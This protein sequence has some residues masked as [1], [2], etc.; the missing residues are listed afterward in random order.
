MP[1]FFLKTKGGYTIIETMIAVSLFI[2]I[3]MTGMGAL[4][5]ANLLHQKS[6]SM[7]SIMDNLSFIMEDMS[8]NLRTG[9]NYYCVTGADNLSNVSTTK[10][11]QNCWGIAFESATGTA[12]PN[13]QWVYYIGTNGIDSNIRIFKSI[14]GPYI[15]SSFI[16]LTPDEV[17]ID[18][19]SSFSVLGA[20][21]PNPD[22]S[23]DHQQPFVVIRLVGSITFK[24]VIT[25]F[26]LQTSVSE[27]VIDI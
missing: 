7:R 9:Y 19:I 5:N 15:Q 12:N 10:S 4:L 23:G 2:I 1:K 8:R 21:A 18:P 6:Q 14:Q 26:S 27:R 17:V 16:Q 3:I 25:P 11:G 13:D 20:E 22:G 24:N